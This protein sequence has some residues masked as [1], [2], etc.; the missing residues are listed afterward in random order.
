MKKSPIVICHLILMIALFLC[1]TFATV[2]FLGGF[3]FAVEGKVRT[4]R[5]L[6]GFST[7]MAMVM[8]IMGILYLFNEY[9][10]QASF[11]YKAFLLIIVLITVLVMIS[12][13]ISPDMNGLILAKCVLSGVKVIV[14]LL[15]AFWKNLGKKKS[16]ILFSIL[17]S[18]DV[19][20]L[21]LVLINMINTS[22]NFSLMGVITA[23]VADGTVGLG[24]RGK[25]I[26][27]AERG[28]I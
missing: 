25:Y 4:D 28:S 20:S 26:D 19:A 8:L 21:I 13:D 1:A 5:L 16:F 6:T 22:F 14:L 18:M 17:I 3:E 9:S 23:I 24:F 2:M 7:I 12:D 27:K 11:F 10:K 15:L